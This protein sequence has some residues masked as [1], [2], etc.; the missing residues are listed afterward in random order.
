MDIEHLGYK[1][2][3][4]LMERGW[5]K[6]PADIYALTEEQLA[7]LPGFKEKSIANLLRAI[8][9]SKVRPLWR[10]LVAL[11]IRHVGSTVARLLAE[12]HPSI[13]ALA[14]A[15]VEQL[16]AIEGI[17]PEIARSVHEWFRDPANRKLIDK[18]RAAGVRMADR[19]AKKRKK[20][21]PLAGKTIVLTGGLQSMS[22]DEAIRAAEE[23]GGKVTSSVSKK[24]DLVVVGTDPGS[25]YDRAVSL[26][27]KIID[28]REFLALVGKG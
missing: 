25:K 19:L 21:G 17:G 20:S 23:A 13:D 22:R 8:E 5:V 16:E 24:T 10:L 4:A 1:T 14:A 7:Q 3:I 18:L 12:A 26:G 6:D 15:D 28:E 2:G 11:S 9:G 27:V